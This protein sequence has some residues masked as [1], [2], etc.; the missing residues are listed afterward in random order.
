MPISVNLVRELESIEPKLRHVLLLLIEELE[1]Q[2]EEPVTK[3][4]F[5]ELKEIVHDLAEAQKPTE[6]QVKE[7]AEAQRRT[8]LEIQKLTGRMDAFEVRL[9]GI[10]SLLVTA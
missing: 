6:A 10:S 3:K 4:G 5:N 2:R 8:E 7:L 1:C 9:E